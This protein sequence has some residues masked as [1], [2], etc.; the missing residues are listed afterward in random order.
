MSKFELNNSSDHV[1]VEILRSIIARINFDPSISRSRYYLYLM[2]FGVKA[3]EAN[4][5][6]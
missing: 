3:K 2:R 1:Y 6:F 4:I 5:K